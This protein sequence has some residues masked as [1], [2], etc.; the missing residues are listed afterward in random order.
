MSA[1]FRK[2]PTQ[3]ERF[4]AIRRALDSFGSGD[5]DSLTHL[6]ALYDAL[7]PSRP[8]DISIAVENYE[9]A[10]TMIE[11]DPVYRENVRRHFLSSFESRNLVTFLTDSGVLPSTG[12]FSE[13]WRIVTN[14][15]LPEVYDERYWKDCLHRVFRRPTD[16]MW[17]EGIPPEFSRRFWRLMESDDSYSKLEIRRIIDQFL[18]AVLILAY[19]ISALG[20]EPDLVRVNP[21][22]AEFA[23]PF[24]ALASEV[25]RF[26]ESYRASI[27]DQELTGDDGRHVL[28]ILSQCRVVL[29]RVRRGAMTKGTN[30]RLTFILAR[31][32]QS[33]DRLESLME[34]LSARF[35]PDVRDAGLK[36]WSTVVRESIRAENKR[37]SIIALCSRLLSL[38][39]LR[40]TDN[41]AKTGE[42]YIATSRTQYFRMWRSA[43]GAGLIIG[44]LA[45][46]K[47]FASKFDTSLANQAF[48]YSMNYGLGFVLIYILHL[49]IATKQPA[50]TA[51]TIAG[52][53]GET[54]GKK[55]KL[56]HVADLTAAVSRTQIAAIMGNVV[57]AFPTAVALGVLLSSFKGA[58]AIDAEK[59]LHLLQTLYPFSS[60]AIPHA[61]VAGVFLF[62]AGLISG[63]FDNKAAYERIGERL[64]RAP[65][66]RGLIGQANAVRI[67]GYIDRNLGGLAGNF[68]FGVMLGSAGTIGKI[69]G[70]PIDIRHIAFSSANFGYALVA[71]DFS[72]PFSVI[73]RAAT[74]VA[75]IG[76]TN[77]AVSFALA[78]WVALASRGVEYRQ[79]KPLLRELWQRFRTQPGSFFLPLR[80]EN[81]S[82]SG[83]S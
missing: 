44:A 2:K 24:L 26:V 69:F 65:W 21:E 76:V 1:L 77:L 16:W 23:S 81:P 63:Y 56:D 73:A 41:A 25:H 60:L 5:Q 12:F 40:V 19:R 64:A 54:P 80:S 45:L 27:V 31:C 38:L 79:M 9:E 71:S 83:T 10:L 62:L 43:M 49:T 3:A 61:A 22:V 82:G 59:G 36:A 11:T 7:R 47:I 46:V 48:L 53:L 29:R 20:V 57:V 55:A 18:E 13:L 32:E 8:T 72:L 15:I 68:F 66:L 58:P 14:R 50:M 35:L 74:G 52:F 37:N 30:L 75:L 67:G 28:V 4:D 17:L 78:L 42:H 39:A 70:L 6:V 33:L 34:M 51:Q